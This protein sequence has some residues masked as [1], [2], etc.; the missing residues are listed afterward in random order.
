MNPLVGWV[1]TMKRQREKRKEARPIQPP[2]I[3]QAV[4]EA[5]LVNPHEA[6]FGRGYRYLVC[7]YS[8]SI[9]DSELTFSTVGIVVYE[10]PPTGWLPDFDVDRVHKRVY[11]VD[12]RER[13][14]RQCTRECTSYCGLLSDTIEYL[15][16]SHGQDWVESQSPDWSGNKLRSPNLHHRG[17]F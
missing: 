12:A 15:R 10:A 7:Q 6:L 11:F 14:L 8:V 2:T 16:S 3:T 17:H 9:R 5:W 13:F 4:C 1:A